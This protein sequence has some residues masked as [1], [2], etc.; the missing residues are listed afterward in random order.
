MKLEVGKKYTVRNKISIK[1]VEI[2]KID[3]RLLYSA[4][5]IITH[6]DGTA[7][8]AVTT[9]FTDGAYAKSTHGH[10]H[11]LIAEYKESITHTVWINMYPDSIGFYVNRTREEADVSASESRIA[12]KENHNNRGRL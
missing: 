8:T 9:F 1:Y 10:F 12:C 6:A 2:I 11:D 4:L 7:D 5:G 3:P